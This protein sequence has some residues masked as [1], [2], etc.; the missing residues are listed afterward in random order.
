MMLLFDSKYS[1]ILNKKVIKLFKTYRDV[2]L[3][4]SFDSLYNSFDFKIAY[5]SNQVSLSPELLSK[6]LT[7]VIILLL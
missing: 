5:V 6:E 1:Y 3:Y 4:N 2:S 7:I